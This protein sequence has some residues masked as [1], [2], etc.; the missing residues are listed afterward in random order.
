MDRVDGQD[1]DVCQQFYLA[2]LNISKS[3]INTYTGTKDEHCNPGEQQSNEPWN[4]TQAALKQKA[5]EHI[6]SK[7][8]IKSHR[9]HATA[10]KYYGDLT[11]EYLQAV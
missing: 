7:P 9:M 3:Q 5:R 4:K 10:N 2:T 8:R 6:A 1:V 11:L